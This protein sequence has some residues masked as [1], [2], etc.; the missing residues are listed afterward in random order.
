MELRELPGIRTSESANDRVRRMLDYLHK[1]GYVVLTHP[2]RHGYQVTGK[3]EYL[4]GL[5]SEIAA[6][7]DALSDEGVVDQMQQMRLAEQSEGVDQPDQAPQ[8][9]SPPDA[10]GRE[11]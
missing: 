10:E 3:I 4:Y 8:D 6:N 11:A 2:N 7:T 1:E 5:L 9:L